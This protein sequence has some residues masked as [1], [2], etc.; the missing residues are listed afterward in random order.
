[1]DDHELPAPCHSTGQRVPQ[2]RSKGVSQVN[3]ILP[4][5]V[6]AAQ[7]LYGTLHAG[8]C[9]YPLE[10]PRVKFL[11]RVYHPNIDDA[12]R[13]CLD[14]LK[15]PPAG[16]WS[17]ASNVST[18]LQSIQLLMNEPNP[19]DAL[20]PDIA[21]QFKQDRGGYEAIARQFVLEHATEAEAAG[22]AAVD[23]GT[24]ASNDAAVA[25]IGIPVVEDARAA[26][27]V[28]PDIGG[29]ASA[30]SAAV[31]EP[32]AVTASSRQSPQTLRGLDPNA[33][34]QLAATKP[35]RLSLKKRRAP[36]AASPGV[37]GVGEVKQRKV[38]G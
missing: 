33:P 34:L 32:L 11:T 18:V 5:H 27:P 7:S 13:I 26:A 4:R 12:G 6:P 3:H 25:N 1:M 28:T 24:P 17:P 36:A 21:T 9:R 8:R 15:A 37:C 31:A 16:S 38:D 23:V 10:P 19:D 20:M 2:F 14:L 35:K 22:A 29:A 30:P